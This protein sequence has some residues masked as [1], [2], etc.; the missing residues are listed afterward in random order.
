MSNSFGIKSKPYELEVYRAQVSLP[1][2]SIGYPSRSTIEYGSVVNLQ[3]T[4]KDSACFDTTNNRLILSWDIAVFSEDGTD[5]E[6]DGERVAKA[7]FTCPCLK[8]GRG[9]SNTAALQRAHNSFSG[10]TVPSPFFL[11]P[12]V[13]PSGAQ[14][15]A[16]S[17]RGRAVYRFT[18]T[19]H[20]EGRTEEQGYGSVFWKRVDI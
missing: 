3:G 9:E 19:A 18:F 13:L 16:S 12:Y 20:P 7:G 8:E 1:T 15:V 11:S 14:L 17:L 10:L 4:V 2:V 6:L 5:L